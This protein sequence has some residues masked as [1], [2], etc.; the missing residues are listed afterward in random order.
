MKSKKVSIATARIKGLKKAPYYFEHT[1]SYVWDIMFENTSTLLFNNLPFIKVGNTEEEGE[2]FCK[3]LKENFKEAQIYDGD[4]VVVI[5]EDD[6]HVLA[7][8]STGKD[9]WI[10][11]TDKFVKKTFAELNIA[12]ESL[13][14]Y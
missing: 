8:G 2:V 5:F 12:I 1:G 4:K 7:I 14:V 9:L 6:G 13:K 3:Q 10:D 11:V